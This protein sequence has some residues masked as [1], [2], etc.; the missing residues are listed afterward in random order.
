MMKIDKTLL[1]LLASQQSVLKLFTRPRRDTTMFRKNYLNVFC[2]ALVLLV[3]G[4]AALA[5][6]APVRGT[7]KLQ[8]ADG[9]VTPVADAVVEAY[10]TDIDKGKMPS[11]KT[12]KRGEFNFVG[13]PLGQRYVLA[14]SGPGIGPRIEPD[15]KGGMEN[16]EFIVNEG[17]GHQLTEAEV[18]AAA[19]GAASAPAGGASEAD[20][21]AQAELAAK[22]AEIMKKNEKLQADD[23]TAR[24]A[25]TEGRAALEAKN[26]D[27][28]IAKFDEG[29]TAVPDYVGSTP[30]LLAGKLLALK[31]RGFDLYVQG[32]KATEAPVKIEKYNAAKKEWLA[33]IAAYGQAA[34]IVKKAP[35]TSD[36]KDQTLRKSIMSDLYAN[37]IEVYRLMAVS[38]VDTTHTADSEALINEYLAQETDA[39]KKAKVQTVLGDI[40]RA[41]G[42]FDKAAAA[43]K[44]VLET[45]PENNEVMASLGLSLVAKAMLV[46]PPSRDDL[47]EGLNYM[48]KYADTVAILPTDSPSVQEFKKSVKD[49]VEYLKTEQKL[50]AQP[51]PKGAKGSATAAPAKKKG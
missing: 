26:Y 40:M 12:N 21:K 3:A 5:Q 25:N 47:Q 7:V 8:K 24:R 13:F 19:K 16:I 27:L 38:Q 14:V 50:K 39:A 17:D 35:P 29:I 1:A 41:A 18:R 43:Y 33:A 6:N 23:E 20:K 31:S 22:N 44:A 10:R 37:T 11:A 34:E 42:E 2:A 36:P 4:T 46:D 9:T 48:Q 49:T 45:S 30:I 32:A 51:P 28:A 15:V